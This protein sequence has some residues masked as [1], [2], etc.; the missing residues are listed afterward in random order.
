MTMLDD[1]SSISISECDSYGGIN[2]N[3][4]ATID[5]DTFISKF[6]AFFKNAKCKKQK[7]DVNKKN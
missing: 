5:K 6:E 2:E 1:I 4:F 3:Y 7:I